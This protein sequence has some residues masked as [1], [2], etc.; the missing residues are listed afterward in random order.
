LERKKKRWILGSVVA[1]MLLLLAGIKY[2]G[3]FRSTSISIPLGLSYYSLMVIGYLTEVYRGKEKACDNLLDYTLFV[4]FFPQVIAG[5]I[6][7]S[8]DLLQQYEKELQFDLSQIRA[9][10]LMVLIGF[11]EKMVLADNINLFVTTVYEGDYE[12]FAVILAI[13]LYSLVIYFDFAGYSLIAIG[14]AKMLGVRLMENFNAPYLACSLQEFWRRWHIS[15]STWLRDYV[16]IPLGGNRKG[17]VRRDFN[18][19]VLFVLSG[20]WHGATAGFVLWG[21]VHGLFMVI[22]KRTQ[23]IRQKLVGKFQKKERYIWLQRGLVY[24]LVSLAWVPFSTGKLW[25]TILVYKN[26][27]SF[28]PWVLS[29]GSLMNAGLNGPTMVVCVLGSLM[30]FA[31]DKYQQNKNFYESIAKDNIIIRYG[32]YLLL[33]TAILLAGGYGAVYHASDFIYGQF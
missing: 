1:A 29:D 30:I 14:C 3:L 31:I 28:N 21:A 6:G 27:F 4:A 32:L 15:L 7:R 9:G 17:T 8:K 23:T 20:A 16:Y 11:F 24:L 18:T 22:G 26:L 5:P 2:F 13:L 33:F 12:G 19:M 25:K 10:F